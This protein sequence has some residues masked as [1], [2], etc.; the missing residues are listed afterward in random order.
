MTRLKTTVVKIL[1]SVMDFRTSFRLAKLLHIFKGYYQD[2]P[3][4]GVGSGGVGGGLRRELMLMAALCEEDRAQL[5]EGPLTRKLFEDFEA[6]FES[7]DG[8]A[9]QF[10]ELSKGQSVEV[11]KEH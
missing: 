9:L 8:K 11:R 3:G 6:L 2:A 5:Y 4:L 10:A 1:K 7:G